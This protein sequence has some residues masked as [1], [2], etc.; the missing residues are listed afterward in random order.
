MDFIQLNYKTILKIP[1]VKIIYVL[2]V[3]TNL[4]TLTNRVIINK[5]CM[6][7]ILN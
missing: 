2:I 4:V 6:C 3:N 5:L 7:L 1:H